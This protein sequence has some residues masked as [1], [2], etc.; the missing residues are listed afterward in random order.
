MLIL[1]LSCT[2]IGSSDGLPVARL[3]LPLDTIYYKIINKR[4]LTTIFDFKTTH[5]ST[6]TVTSFFYIV[7]LT[8]GRPALAQLPALS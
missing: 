3:I 8:V 7:T 5:T 1:L 4:L 6:A 2:R